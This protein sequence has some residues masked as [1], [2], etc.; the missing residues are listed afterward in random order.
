MFTVEKVTTKIGGNELRK[1]VHSLTTHR[2]LP[3]GLQ[4]L[5]FIFLSLFVFWAYMCILHKVKY[6]IYPV[7]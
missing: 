2:K 7:V 4:F 3:L 5:S 6:N 1:K